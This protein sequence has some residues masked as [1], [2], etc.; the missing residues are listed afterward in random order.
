MLIEEAKWFGKALQAIDPA[1]ISPMLNVGSS[2]AEF[3]QQRQ[4]WIEDYIFRPL[5]RNGV[6][7]LNLDL[8][9]DPGVDIVG[10]LSDPALLERLAD[11]EFRSVFC[12]NILEHVA[13]RGA[14]CRAVLSLLPR[15][16]LVFVSCPYAYP[17]HPDPID[18]MYRPG[19]TELAAAFPGTEFVQGE[20]VT[21]APYAGYAL[22]S[23]ATALRTLARLALPFPNPTGWRME[24]D[25]MRWFFRRFQ[26][27][28]LVLDKPV[29]ARRGSARE[30]SA[31]ASASSP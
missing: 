6:R 25:H 3:R 21:C 5:Q 23:P 14:F 28:C 15:G 29:P 12:S 31:T 10:D 9:P 4:P 13:G 22:R 24:L 30:R 19:V 8:K 7:V 18:M 2:T 27:T 1:A 26:A 20:I 17:F 16:G 11:Y